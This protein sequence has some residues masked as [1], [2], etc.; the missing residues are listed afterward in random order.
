MLKVYLDKLDWLPA[1]SELRIVS[2]EGVV[3]LRAP[4]RLR[5]NGLQLIQIRDLPSGEYRLQLDTRHG[6]AE[7]SFSR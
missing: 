5:G 4:S 1:E 3:R 6:I 2:A 7:L